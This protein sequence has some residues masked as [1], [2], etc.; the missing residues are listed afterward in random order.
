[1]FVQGAVILNYFIG[2]VLIAYGVFAL[3][4]DITLVHAWVVLLFG[5]ILLAKELGSK[6]KYKAR[7]NGDGYTSSTADYTSGGSDS[8]SG[9]D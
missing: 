3:K 7:G 1:V 4:T 5:I 6:R 8:G 9:G 2:F